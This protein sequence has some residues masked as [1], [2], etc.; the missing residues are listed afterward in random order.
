MINYTFPDYLIVRADGYQWRE[1]S[2]FITSQPAAGSYYSQ[3]VS[4]DVPVFI[5]F[6]IVAQSQ[7]EALAFRSWLISDNFAVLSGAP[8]NMPIWTEYGLNMEVVS[9]T[10]D[11]LPRLSQAIRGVYIYSARVLLNKSAGANPLATESD[12]N[13]ETQSGADLE[14]ETGGFL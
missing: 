10:P 12:I 7:P 9:F 6:E 11:G 3:I 14:V 2:R 1:E 8:F 4:D 13:I 5:E